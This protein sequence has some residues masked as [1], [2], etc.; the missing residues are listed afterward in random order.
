MVHSFEDD[1]MHRLSWQTVKRPYIDI[2][3]YG[4][5]IINTLRPSQIAV[6]VLKENVWISIRLSLKFVPWV[7]INSKQALVQIRG[8]RLIGDKP[9]SE[10]MMAYFIDAYMRHSASMPY[11]NASHIK[12]MVC[13]SKFMPHISYSRGA[14]HSANCDIFL[15]IHEI[16]AKSM[17]S[18]RYICNCDKIVIAF[19]R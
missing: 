5:C 19:I 1:Q 4:S 10:P 3:L 2:N 7:S 9:L 11:I 14:A 13:A 17:Y 18:Q 16:S 12:D 15:F 8:W 6:I